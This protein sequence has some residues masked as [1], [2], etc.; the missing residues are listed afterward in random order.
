MAVTTAKTVENMLGS[1]M[2]TADAQDSMIDLVTL[3][4]PD[5]RAMQDAGNFRWKNVQQRRPVITGWD[6]SNEAQGIIRETYPQVL[7]T[8]SNDVIIWA[9]N[10]IH[11][12][13]SSNLLCVKYWF[14][15]W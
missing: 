3:D 2:E 13:V 5:G 6:V 9:I 14:L 7:G 4:T 15:S 1:Y 8:P 10:C 12:L 11:G